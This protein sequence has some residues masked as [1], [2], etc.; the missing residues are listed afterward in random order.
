MVKTLVTNF[1]LDEVLLTIIL[2]GL[3]EIQSNFRSETSSSYYSIQ[4]IDAIKLYETRNMPRCR[5]NR[6]TQ[7]IVSVEYLFGRPVIASNFRL[8]KCHLELS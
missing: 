8:V 1:K 7:R 6:G 4:A 3:R 5:L 2:R